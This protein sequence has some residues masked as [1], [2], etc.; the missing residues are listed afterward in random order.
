MA[1]GRLRQRCKFSSQK[2]FIFQFN[3]AQSLQQANYYRRRLQPVTI[4][5]P[6]FL[7]HISSFILDWFSFG[8]LLAREVLMGKSMWEFVQP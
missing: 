5:K 8:T 4:S 2:I 7:R 6:W 3:C 1:G